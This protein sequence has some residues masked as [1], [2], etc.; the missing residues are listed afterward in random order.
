MKEE[1]IPRILVQES[2]DLELWL[3]RY[4]ILKF[5]GYFCER[6]KERAMD[7]VRPQSTMDRGGVAKSVV[8]RPL[9]LQPPAALAHRH[10]AATAGEG[11]WGTGV[12]PQ[13]S[14]V[15][16]ECLA[17]AHSGHGE[18]G[19]RGGGGVVRRG[20]AGAPFYRVGGEVGQPDG[21]GNR[22]AGGGAP[23]WQPVR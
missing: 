7:H 6:K 3:K 19:R 16:D 18:R 12:S 13:G 9:E 4:G 17:Q 1:L 10:S 22:A 23:L 14:A 5:R 11:E 15:V 8:V 2:L 21:K 20:G